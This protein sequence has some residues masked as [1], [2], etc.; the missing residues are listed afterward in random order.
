M[1]CIGGNN[2]WHSSV[3]VVYPRRALPPKP[4]R[5]RRTKNR[6][7]HIGEENRTTKWAA[8][9]CVISSVR[10]EKRC[11]TTREIIS[12]CAPS[13]CVFRHHIHRICAPESSRNL[14]SLSLGPAEATTTTTTMFLHHHHH[15]S[16][17][18]RACSY[19]LG[20]HKVNASSWHKYICAYR[21]HLGCVIYMVGGHTHCNLP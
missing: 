5:E 17:Q 1:R 9:K 8:R 3:S 4:K 18:C 13:L 19:V 7:K 21:R 11:G 20:R 14:F 2:L 10:G 6:A 12:R 15:Q 16:N